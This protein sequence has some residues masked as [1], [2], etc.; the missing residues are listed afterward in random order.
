MKR[1]HRHELQTHELQEWSLE[2]KLFLERYATAIVVGICAV[3]LLGVGFWAWRQSVARGE[4]EAWAHLTVATSHQQ[5]A[6]VA[7]K[8]PGTDVAR[9]ARLREAELLLDE[10]V[11]AE[12]SSRELSKTQLKTAEE[13]FRA[14]LDDRRLTPAQRQRALFG[15]A[16]V[17]EATSDSNL[18]P[19]IDAYEEVISE[20][21]EDSVFGK[22]AK[23]RIAALK[24]PEAAAFYAWFHNQNPQPRDRD[25]PADLDS[26]MRHDLSTPP[27][28]GDDPKGESS[29]ADGGSPPVSAT[30]PILPEPGGSDNP[31]PPPL[32][33]DD[34]PPAES[35]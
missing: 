13:R 17:L 19:A 12:F 24:K 11:Q 25:R 32:P 26:R 9:W 23:E 29:G 8:F 35:P 3:A 27:L 34:S 18:A 10:G 22:L 1:E 5:F 31:P 15:L 7:D 4:N 16:S 2:A 14:L 21:G 28:S 33:V 20:F 30:A 6:E